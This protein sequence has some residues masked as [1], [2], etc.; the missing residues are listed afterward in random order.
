M[1]GH[2]IPIIVAEQ[3]IGRGAQPTTFI[4]NM[5]ADGAGGDSK[6]TYAPKP[7]YV[8]NFYRSLVVMNSDVS[9]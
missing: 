3:G 6:S 5:L 9:L 7:L 8:T 2:R 1:K 4:L